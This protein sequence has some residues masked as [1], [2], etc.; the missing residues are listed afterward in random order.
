[1][2]ML[3]TGAATAV[4]GIGT[5]VRRKMMNY[6]VMTPKR[7]LYYQ[8]A[9]ENMADPAK[10]RELADGF[11]KL[12]L[13]EAANNLRG[14]AGVKALP[15]EVKAKHKEMLK[16]GLA[17]EKPLAILDLAA[18]FDKIHLTGSANRLRAHAAAISKKNAVASI[19]PLAPATPAAPVAPEAAPAAPPAPDTTIAP[20]AEM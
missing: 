19:I 13:P 9:M 20:P 14:R 18:A 5:V 11:D 16:K 1:M 8:T 2:W 4:V 12:G 7:L 10:L 3:A 6:G 15:P 17:S